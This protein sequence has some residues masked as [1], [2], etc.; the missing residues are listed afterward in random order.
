MSGPARR[1]GIPFVMAAA[2]GTGKTTVC[3]AIAER[4]PQVV[5]SVSHTTRKRRPGERDGVDYHFVDEPGFRALVEAGAFLEWAEYAGN[6][7]GTSGRELERALDGGSDV[8]LEIEIQGARQV[9]DRRS[10]ARLI[11]LVPPSLGELEA[12]L[13]G[14][15]SDAD[16]EIERR[17]TAAARELEAARW[18]DYAVVNDDLEQAI[19]DTLEIVA[20]ER[21]GCGSA[22]ADRF[23]PDAALKR[24]RGA[25][26]AR[27]AQ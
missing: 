25:P 26:Q 12:R 19:E 10:D 17:L 14:R 3:R 22:L 23:A 7:Y 4:D 20:A 1:R 16:A 24:I 6:L 13:R 9:R 2:S 11:F 15:G 27:R 8:L 21:T 5:F 18:F